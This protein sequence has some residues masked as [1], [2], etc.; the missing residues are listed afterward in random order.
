MF[1]EKGS[2][3]L[4]KIRYSRITIFGSSTRNVLYTF[5]VGAF[6]GKVQFHARDLT[7]IS[8]S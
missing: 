4:T 8:A 2:A 3:K 5:F 7:R 6:L 1:L